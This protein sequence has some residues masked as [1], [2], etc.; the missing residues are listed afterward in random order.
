MTGY[1]AERILISALDY[2][3]T[4]ND[5]LLSNAARYGLTQSSILGQKAI[6]DDVAEDSR[7]ARVQVLTS[8]QVPPDPP[9]LPGS[10]LRTALLEALGQQFDVVL[11]DTAALLAVTDAAV[12]APV[13][14]GVLLVVGRAQ[15]MREAVRAACRELADVRAR[16][17]GVVVN[18]AEQGGSY[19]HCDRRPTGHS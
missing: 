14:D 19:S 3:V 4:L 11:F 1:Q 16:S 18:R 2:R 7:I 17:V 12:L 5:V 8:G 15:A 9:E 6:L 10:P 13:V